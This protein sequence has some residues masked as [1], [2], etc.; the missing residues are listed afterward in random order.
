MYNNLVVQV[1]EGG[2]IKATGRLLDIIIIPDGENSPHQRAV[3]LNQ[4]NS[5]IE[6]YSLYNYKLKVINT[7]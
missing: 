5:M 3:I 2:Y 4:E 7:K 1:I 6:I